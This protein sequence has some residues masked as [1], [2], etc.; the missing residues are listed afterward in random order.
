MSSVLSNC[1]IGYKL[2]VVLDMTTG[3]LRVVEYYSKGAV[4][5]YEIQDDHLSVVPVLRNTGHFTSLT[6]LL[7]V[8]DLITSCALR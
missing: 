3:P 6:R 1:S 5:S 2:I 4:K 8:S 7:E